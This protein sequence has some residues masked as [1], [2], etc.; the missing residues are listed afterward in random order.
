MSLSSP[1]HPLRAH[2][3]RRCRPWR[4]PPSLPG[5]CNCPRSPQPRGNRAKS[6][7]YR[8]KGEKESVIDINEGALTSSHRGQI[9]LRRFTSLA[10]CAA[11]LLQRYSDTLP[12][13]WWES[14]IA[15]SPPRRLRSSGAV[16]S[17]AS[18]SHRLSLSK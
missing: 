14:T 17:K 8:S 15:S 9:A 10:L 2:C 5:S 13:G 12:T 16:A 18:S 11:C 1:S 6:R 4:R 3:R 7:T